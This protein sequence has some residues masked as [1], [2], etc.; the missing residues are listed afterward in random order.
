[1]VL[2]GPVEEVSEGRLTPGFC[3]RLAAAESRQD[4][5]YP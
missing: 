3:A 2:R 4:G 1:V 5:A